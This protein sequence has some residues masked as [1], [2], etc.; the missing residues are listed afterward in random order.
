MFK[1]SI[2]ALSVAS[3]AVFGGVACTDEDDDGAVTD[4]EVG[5]IDETVDDAGNELEQEI[6]QGEA[7]TDDQP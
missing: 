3:L 1:R 5:E 6:D 2:A 7:E 4:E